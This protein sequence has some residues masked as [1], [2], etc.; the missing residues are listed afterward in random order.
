LICTT[1]MTAVVGVMFIHLSLHIKGHSFSQV[2]VIPGLLL[3]VNCWL[4]IWQDLNTLQVTSF[5]WSRILDKICHYFMRRASCYCLCAPS[6][7]A[8]A[9]VVFASFVC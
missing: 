5:V 8:T 1:S 4:K 2:Q 9:Q 3:L 7:F 6:R